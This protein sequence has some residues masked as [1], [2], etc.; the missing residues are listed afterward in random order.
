MKI[1]ETKKLEN[2]KKLIARYFKT[3]KSD[4][5]KS[6]VQPTPINYYE[7][8]CVITNLIKMCILTL[9]QEEHKISETNKNPVN[10]SLILE[11]ILEMF[12]LDEFE[13]LSDINQILVE[14]S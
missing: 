5:D 11:T 7:L 3:V 9:D 6:E 1:D 14:D 12:P 13:L 2:L 10:V 8:G 4:N